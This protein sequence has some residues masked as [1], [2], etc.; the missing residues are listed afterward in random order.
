MVVYMNLLK[1][2][3]NYLICRAAKFCGSCCAMADL[4]CKTS[5][6]LPTLLRKGR[7]SRTRTE[8]V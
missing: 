8:I 5:N 4:K 6:I 1:S 2:P 3:K 7:P